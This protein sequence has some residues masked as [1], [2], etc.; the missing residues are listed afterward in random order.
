MAI[1]TAVYGALP[2]RRGE[3]CDVW[4]QIAPMAARHKASSCMSDLGTADD[5]FAALRQSHTRER[6]IDVPAAA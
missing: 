4:L 5:V 2:G 3:E 6:Y 1:L